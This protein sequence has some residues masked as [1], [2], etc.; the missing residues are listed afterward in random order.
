M[1]MERY[2]FIG[3]PVFNSLYT[4]SEDLL[5]MSVNPVILDAL[6]LGRL[7]QKRKEEGFRSIGKQLPILIFAENLGLG[8]SDIKR[9][10]WIRLR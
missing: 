5:W 8:S 1:P 10:K 4:R 3:G 2:Q 9:I 6:I 7:N